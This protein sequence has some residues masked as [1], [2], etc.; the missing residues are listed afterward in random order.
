MPDF[1]LSHSS[2]IPETAYGTNVISSPVIQYVT[3]LL[4]SVVLLHSHIERRQSVLI[5]YFVFPF[6]PQNSIGMASQLLL[7][8]LTRSI[9]ESVAFY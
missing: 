1:P 3:T 4:Y 7:V 2:K 9:M 5:L 6:E 8:E